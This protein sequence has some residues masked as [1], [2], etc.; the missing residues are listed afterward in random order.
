MKLYKQLLIAALSLILGCAGEPKF[1]LVITNATIWTGN[2]ESPHAEA[3]VISADTLVFVGTND[4]VSHYLNDAKIVKDAAGMFIVPGFIDTHVHFLQGGFNLASVKLRDAATPEEFAQRI[5]EFAKTVPAGTWILGGEWD[6]E[7][8]GG[9]LPD[10]A[11]IDELTPDHPVYVTRLDGHMSLANSKVIEL[12]GIQ[13]SVQDIDG[14]EIVRDSNGRL[15]GIFK[16]NAE[17]LIYPHIPDPS[18]FQ[19]D[20]ALAMAMNYVASNGVTSVHDMSGDLDVI[21]R[22]QKNGTQITRYYA[23]MPLSRWDNV[24]KLV[25]ERGYGDEW[26]RIGGLKGFVDGSLGSHTAAFKEPYTDTPTDSGFFVNTE[27]DLYEW[28]LNADKAGLQ[29]MIHAIGDRANG[30]LLDNFER[31]I[32]DNGPKDRRF[33]IEHAQHISPEDI[34]RFAELDVI[35]SMQP[36]HAIDDGRWAERVIGPERIKTTYAFKSLLDAGAVVAFG[37]DWFVAPPTPIEGI[38][39]AVTRRTLDDNNPDGWVPNQKITIEE[40]LRSYTYY[41]AFASFEEDVKGT[42]TPGKL[43]DFVILDKNLFEIDPESIRTTNVIETYVG[44]IQVYKK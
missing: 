39:A 25:D 5:G 21:E 15:T 32:N 33:R 8:W 1:D 17:R 41:G 37:S 29:V 18:S 16:D 24:K 6:H 42:L 11:W 36:Y 13:D 44:G 9:E 43:A 26:I 35:G 20:Q 2:P 34:P 14:G 10:R 12:A 7:N 23:V 40:A 4:E 30:F 28:T 38:Y 27:E 22:A 3:M 19:N 31:V